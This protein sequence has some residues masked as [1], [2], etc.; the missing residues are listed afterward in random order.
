MISYEEVQ[1]HTSADDCWVIV[2]V[3]T[4]PIA[5]PIAN[6]LQGGYRRAKREKVRGMGRRLL[7]D[8]HN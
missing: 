5:K 3:S 4:L 6:V 2:D 1:K 7:Y 8:A